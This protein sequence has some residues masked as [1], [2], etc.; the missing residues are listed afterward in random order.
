MLR[1]GLAPLLKRVKS[2]KRWLREEMGVSPA[3][4][5]G[6]TA[7]AEKWSGVVTDLCGDVRAEFLARRKEALPNGE[8]ECAASEGIVPYDESKYCDLFVLMM[9]LTQ[10]FDEVLAKAGEEGWIHSFVVGDALSVERLH[11]LK[12]KL[13]CLAASQDDDIKDTAYGLYNSLAGFEQWMG[14]MHLLMADIDAVERIYEAVITPIAAALNR[15]RLKR[16]DLKANLREHR[17]FLFGLVRQFSY[18]VLIEMAEAGFLSRPLFESG[19]LR[20]NCFVEAR[21]EFFATGETNETFLYATR[22]LLNVVSTV[23]E[24]FECVLALFLFDVMFASC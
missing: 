15:K 21:D 18:A 19:E 14:D 17:H 9:E 4:V 13:L 8:P 23:N 5:A 3:A 1:N 2:D 22:Q 11:G 24:L 12:Q 10:L 7:M 6:L 16:S 20:V